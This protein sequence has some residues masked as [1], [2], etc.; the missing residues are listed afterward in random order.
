VSIEL[1]DASFNGAED[2]EKL[3]ILQGIR[4]LHGC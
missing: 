4:F 2:T 3:G 1:E